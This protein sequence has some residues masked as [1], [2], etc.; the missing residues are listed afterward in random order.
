MHTCSECGAGYEDEDRYCPQCGN[1]LAE[2]NATEAINTQ[3][4][5]DLFDVQ[6]KLG[7]VYYRKGDY[8]RAVETWEKVLARRPG[9]IDLASLVEDA[10]SRC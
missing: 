3:E 5:L 7:L 2:G 1:R 6:Y 8:P 4:S 10:R 9:D